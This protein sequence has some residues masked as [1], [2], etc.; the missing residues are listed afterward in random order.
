MKRFIFPII[1]HLFASIGISQTGKALFLDGAGDYMTVADHTDLNIKKGESFTL[2]CWVKTSTSID[3]HRIVSK[4]GGSAASNSG[5]EMIIQ[6]GTGNLGINLRS[7]SGTNAGP[8]FG[9]TTISDGKW[10]HVAMVV[11]AA[12]HTSKIYV[13]GKLD[14]TNNSNAIGAESFQNATSLNIGASAEPS[15]YWNGWLDEIR[16]WK[17]ALS[18]NEILKDLTQTVTETEPDIVAAW[19]FENVEDQKVYDLSGIHPGTLHGNAQILDPYVDN[20]A[21]I[22]AAT[23]QPDLP[24]GQGEVNERLVSINFKTIGTSNPLILSH[25]KFKLNKQTDPEAIQTVRLFYNGHFNRFKLADAQLLGT[26]QVVGDEIYFPMSRTLEEGD[27]YFWLCADISDVAR[28]GTEIGAWLHTY[29]KNGIETTLDDPV[30]QVLRPVLLKHKLLF[31]GG[32]YGSQHYR[33]PA[34]ASRGQRIVVVADARISNNG[35]LPGNI[36]LISRFSEDGGQTWSSPVIVADFGNN[37][38]SD[39]ALVYDKVTGDLL[40]LFASHNGLFASTPSNKI[41]FQVARSSDF[42]ETWSTPKEFSSQIYRTGWYAAWVAS[43]SAHQLPDGRIVAAIGV[44]KNSSSTISNFM[45]YSDDG[46][47]S[48]QTAPGQASP[49]GDE[50]KIVSLDDGR[51]LM[52]IRSPGQRKVTY[53]SDN[54]NTWSSPISKPELVE[55][56]VNG[57]LIRYTSV[58]S[59]YDKSR[60]LFSIASHPKQR[61]N[62]TVFVSYDEGE[63][64]ATRRVIVPGLAAYSAMTAFEDGTI[65]LFYEN[66]E[67]ENYQ[68]NFAR[69]SLDW[70]TNGA[71][72]WSPSV[73]TSDPKVE[74]IDLSVAPNPS[75]SIVE[76]KFNS[77]GEQNVALE[78]FDVNGQLIKTLMPSGRYIGNQR[79]I[80]DTKGIN[81][82]LFFV[83]LSYGTRSVMHKQVILK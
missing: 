42:G 59:G 44:R 68:L 45:I 25:F 79:V 64:W 62:L 51:L 61:R 74:E 81:K 46:G 47:L 37:G 82:G 7:T 33:I 60:L 73:A 13:D 80:W 14:Q 48:W 58:N 20:M 19:N 52:A 1:F 34:I 24:T 78:I 39:P 55:P 53:S 11:N 5:F 26:A 56:G 40:C 69:F 22:E 15:F 21:L 16:I 43:G 67:Y 30:N 63:T 10:H 41:R 77:S 12:A 4:R 2:T 8:P 28:E 38:A 75:S 31:S 76:I 29:S 6:S 57:D 18:D 66:G 49:T 3:Y 32:D 83:R 27:N 23:Y 70:L 65:G 71:D 50:A 72:T 9:T 35:D 54:G 36:D 17:K